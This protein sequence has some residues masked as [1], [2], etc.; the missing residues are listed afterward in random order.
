MRFRVENLGPVREA[1]VD[2]SKDLVVLTGPNNTGKTYVAW[3]LYGLLRF[4]PTALHDTIETLCDRLLTQPEH[5]VALDEL[6]PLWQQFASSLAAD[7]QRELPNCFA[8][9]VEDFQGASVHLTIPAPE[10]ATE[11]LNSNSGSYSTV[12]GDWHVLL[13][14]NPFGRPVLRLLLRKEPFAS[15]A[16]SVKTIDDEINRLNAVSQRIYSELLD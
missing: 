5:Q 14:L 2:L 1:E 4:R 3:S 16:F 8:S 7:Y 15:A 13:L 11:A 12:V 9:A 6:T 10:A